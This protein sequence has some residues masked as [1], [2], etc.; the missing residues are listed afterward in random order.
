MGFSEDRIHSANMTFLGRFSHWIFAVVTIG[1]AQILPALQGQTI[2]VDIN[3]AH[4]TNSFVP[5]ESLGAG[6]DRIPV[7][8]IDHD[9]EPATLDRVFAAGWQP[10]S[11]RQNTD[12]AVEA[13][14]WNPE[15]TW[16]AAWNQGLLHRINDSTETHSLLLSG[17][18]CLIAA[19]RTTM[20]PATPATRASPMARRVPT[21][22]AIPI[23]PAISPAKTMRC[24]RSGSFSISTTKNSWTPSRSHGRRPSRSRYLVQ[25][26]NGPV[27]PD[28]KIFG[29][30]IHSPTK[31]TWST[32]AHGAISAGNGDSDPLRLSDFPIHARYLRIWMTQ[33]SNTCDTHGASDPRNCV[34]YAIRELYMR[35]PP[36]RMASSTICC[37]T[38]LTRNR[39]RPIPPRQIRG[40]TPK[41]LQ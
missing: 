18:P 1:S 15:G 32:F 25:Y 19:S 23:S 41:P 40:M 12:L 10:V 5:R 35:A 36:P 33:S 7:A 16:S 13:W 2:R 37:A 20:A 39:R 4:K 31:G 29:D 11:Y 30:P 14:H 38:R 26:W 6:I 24:I 17:W 28:G 8:A 27:D 9:L 22:R 21:G 3:P 34:G